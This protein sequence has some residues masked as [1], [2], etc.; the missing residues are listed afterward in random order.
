MFSVF[1]V[2]LVFVMVFSSLGM[3][4]QTVFAQDGTIDSSTQPEEGQVQV[5]SPYYSEQVITE[6]DGRTLL[7]SNI[8]GPAHPVNG[9]TPTKVDVIPSSAV[10]LA[11]SRL[12]HGSLAAQRFLDQ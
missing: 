11:M 7:V 4:S 9:F 5:I 6:G 2:L 12:I 10:T 3:T 8:N 1:A